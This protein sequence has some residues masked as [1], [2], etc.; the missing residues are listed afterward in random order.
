LFNSTCV[1][2]QQSAYA[3]F[4]VSLAS[5]IGWAGGCGDILCTGMNNYLIH[6]HTGTLFP[7]KGVLIANNSDIGD[8]T[9]GCTF[10]P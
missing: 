8:N 9:I 4:D 3:K 2:C 7:F 5:H 6:D 10:I 1:N